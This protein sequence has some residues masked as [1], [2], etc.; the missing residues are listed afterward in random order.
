MIFCDIQ[1]PGKDGIDMMEMLDQ[2]Q[3]QG[4]VV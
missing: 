4:Q 2:I 3:Y 1:M